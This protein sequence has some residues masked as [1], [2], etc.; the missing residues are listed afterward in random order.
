MELL[1][2]KNVS[3]KLLETSTTGTLKRPGWLYVPSRIL[4]NILNRGLLYTLRATFKPWVDI[5][6]SCLC[7][8]KPRIK[9][10]HNSSKEILG[11]KPGE[12]V[13]VKSW[14]EILETLDDKGKF[15]GLVFTP[16]M[17]K[18]CSQEFRVFKRLEFMFDECTRGKRRLKNTVLLEGAMCTGE[19]IGCDR[20]CFHYW[21]ELW[22]RR[23]RAIEGGL[24]EK[25]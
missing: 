10:K 18:L 12:R 25:G 9:I 7:I 5:V 13:E 6:L 14:N 21:R 15:K 19:G 1:S 24:N 4:F 23:A 3:C 16:E 2:F 11:L 17:K 20:S 8:S 22:L